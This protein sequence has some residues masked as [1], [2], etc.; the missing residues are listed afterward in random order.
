[1]FECSPPF[2]PRTYIR[3]KNFNMDDDLL[4]D[5]GDLNDVMVRVPEHCSSYYQAFAPPLFCFYYFLF[6]I[7][8]PPSI[9]VF[10]GE[11]YQHGYDDSKGDPNVKPRVSVFP[12]LLLCSTSFENITV[13]IFFVSFMTNAQ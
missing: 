13:F 12:L 3:K 1:M 7:F 2:S 9:P 6:L 11:D 8:P 4:D 5:L 10:Q